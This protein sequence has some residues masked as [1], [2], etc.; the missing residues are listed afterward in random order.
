MPADQVMERVANDAAPAP[1]GSRAAAPDRQPEAAPHDQHGQP[2]F[3]PDPEQR[4][5]RYRLVTPYLLRL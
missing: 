1:P 2:T 5:D 4:T 3:S